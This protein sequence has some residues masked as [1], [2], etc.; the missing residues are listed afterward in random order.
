LNT[1]SSL[2]GGP[3]L[4]RRRAAPLL[5]NLP[6]TYAKTSEAPAIEFFDSGTQHFLRFVDD[7]IARSLLDSGFLTRTAQIDEDALNDARISA[8]S[9]TINA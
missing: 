9:L 4:K 8:S 3:K 1:I 6:E 2:A 7:Q 5:P